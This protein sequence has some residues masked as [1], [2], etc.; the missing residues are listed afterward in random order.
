M[1]YLQIKC[2]F[3]TNDGFSKFIS[4]ISKITDFYVIYQTAQ[5]NS[6]FVKVKTNDALGLLSK[7]SDYC[8]EVNIRVKSINKIKCKVNGNC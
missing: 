8:N 4:F 6:Y 7:I 3:I 5:T 1:V 2:K